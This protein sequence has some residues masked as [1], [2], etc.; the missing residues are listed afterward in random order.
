[1]SNIHTPTDLVLS[2]CLDLGTLTT[3]ASASFDTLRFTRAKLVIFGTTG[4]GSTLDATLQESNDN[5]ASDPWANVA[6]GAIST[7]LA[8]ASKG[9]RL[10]SIDLSHRKRYLRVQETIAGTVVGSIGI[11][12]YNPEEAPVSQDFPPTL[13]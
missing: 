4:P 8:G 11:E 6:G 1:M 13:V 10:V 7:I 9:V 2:H 3:Q 12:L 5:G